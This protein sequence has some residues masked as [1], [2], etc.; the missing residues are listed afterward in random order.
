MHYGHCTVDP[1]EPHVMSLHQCHA[2]LCRLE[3]A[4]TRLWCTEVGAPSSGAQVTSI[5]IDSC[6]QR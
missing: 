5:P 6:L 3:G 4:A 2:M 1:V